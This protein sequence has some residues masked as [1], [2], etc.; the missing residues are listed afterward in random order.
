MS[1]ERTSAALDVLRAP[2]ASG[3]RRR[4]GSGSD[5]Q[6]LIH[7]GVAS[8]NLTAD[9]LTLLA[10]LGYEPAGVVTGSAVYYVAMAIRRWKANA[11]V[12]DLT[13]ALVE[14]RHQAMS[15]LVELAESRGAAAIGAVR[16][17]LAVFEPG[18]QHHRV[19]LTALGT[20]LS[21]GP[22]PSARPVASTLSGR[23]LYL[24]ESSGY[25]VLGAVMGSCVY[26]VAHRDFAQ[27][28]GSQ[29]S[30]V[31][32]TQY[33]DALYEAR[34]L[35]MLRMQDE[36]EALKADGVVD[37]T[38]TQRSHIWGSRIIEFFAMGTAVRARARERLLET[39]LVVDL[40]S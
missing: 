32:M 15:S 20:A 28:V 33:T 4:T 1:A 18:Q 29:T 37:V 5:T 34:E 35:A 38:V 23:D 8:S 24:L 11:E 19:T 6:G 13:Q 40:G 16:L 2:L 9:E 31:E 12:A 25:R 10:G 21:G 36:P 39:A 7:T 3:Q 22:R 14:A 30:N 27:W 17:E 26:H